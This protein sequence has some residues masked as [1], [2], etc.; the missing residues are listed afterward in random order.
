MS[1]EL[2]FQDEPDDL[3]FQQQ[4]EPDIDLAPAKPPWTLLVVDDEESVHQVTRLALRDLTY[5][6]RPLSILSAYSAAEARTI[7]LDTPGIA[8]ILLDVVMETEHAGLEL[9]RFIRQDLG[10]QDVRLV[11]RTGQPGQ[12]PEMSVISSYDINDYKDK[13]ELTAQ[14]LYTLLLACL[15]SYRDIEILHQSRL[16][17]QNVM[18]IA[19]QI[20]RTQNYPSFIKS[21]LSHLV[22]LLNVDHNIVYLFEAQAYEVSDQGYRL[23]QL[24]PQEKLMEEQAEDSI[25]EPLL[26]LLQRCRQQREN[27]YDQERVCIFCHGYHRELMFVL[28]SPRE[29]TDLDRN[30]VELLSDNLNIALENIDLN[31]KLQQSQRDVIYRVTELV[32]THSKEGG[33][34]VHRVALYSELLAR[35]A[36]LDEDE[37]D[38]IKRSAPLHDLGKIGIPDR[39]LKKPGR[40][41]EEEWEIMK[42]H[43]ELG[44]QMLSGSGL[45]LLDQGAI[46]S[47]SHHEHWD[48]TGYP[49]G[50]KG[51]QIPMVGR[52]TSLADVYDAL[53]S[54]RCYKEVWSNSAIVAYIEARSGSD[55]DPTLVRLFRDNIDQFLAIKDRLGDEDSTDDHPIA[56]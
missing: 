38:M 5:D 21:S 16:G 17:L 24:K 9:A 23:S 7:L 30:L 4:D 41:D 29:L 44:Y 49:K 55:F 40:L 51:E 10:N 22:D 35:L 52:I 36:G 46:I 31:E 6:G 14:K 50:L 13:T 47:L 33:S 26:D 8:V 19:R 18:E 39:V 3:L 54:G 27:I 53:G 15:R 2:L 12:A 32:E 43:S 37:V 20:F 48:G 56:V 28:K 34:H 42:R 25:S 1:D 11:L 45:P